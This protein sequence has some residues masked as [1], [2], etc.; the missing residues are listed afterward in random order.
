LLDL[1]PLPG[2]RGNDWARAHRRTSAA[3][4]SVFGLEDLPF[5]PPALMVEPLIAGGHCPTAE[6]T[7]SGMCKALPGGRVGAIHFDPHSDPSEAHLVPSRAAYPSARCSRGEGDRYRAKIWCELAGPV[8]PAR[9]FAPTVPGRRDS[10][11]SPNGRRAAAGLAIAPRFL[12][13]SIK[14]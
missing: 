4:G 13:R 5:S 11:S 9:P 10:P 6:T 12:D 14:D 1:P 7:I 8:S 2:L 3:T